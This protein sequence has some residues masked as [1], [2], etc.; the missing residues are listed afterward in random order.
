MIGEMNHNGYIF[1]LF[2]ALLWLAPSFKSMSFKTN[3]PS[4][5]TTKH[6]LLKT[7]ATGFL[8][9][10]FT[11]HF[12]S[13]VTAAMIDLKYPFSASKDV[14]KFLKSDMRKNTVL[15]GDKDYAVSSVAGYLNREIY[16][17]RKGDFGTFVIW[18][19]DRKKDLNDDDILNN[20]YT[21][22]REVQKD[23][24]L[25][26]NYK[27]KD[28]LMSKYHLKEIKEFKESI[29]WDEKFYLYSIEYP[30]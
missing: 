9:I 16:Y 5:A 6:N 12:L 8:M 21:K 22:F 1:I 25:I 19:I 2:I 4:W 17:P 13:G 26:F 3:Y 29:V 23:G 27:L 10:V 30:S 14:S 20:I 7:G 15:A 18:N 24:I 11:I 28:D